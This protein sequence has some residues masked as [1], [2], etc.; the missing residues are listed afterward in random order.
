VVRVLVVS[1]RGSAPRE[2][3]ACMLVSRWGLHGTVGGGRLEYQAQQAAQ[4]LLADTGGGAQLQ[5]F[6]LGA[7]L[8]QCCGGVVELWIERY[9]R[10]ELPL[11]E[12]AA[13]AGADGAPAGLF[14]LLR[15]DRVERRVLRGRPAARL[16]EPVLQ[17]RAGLIA[18]RERLHRPAPPLWLF[19]AGHVGQALVRVLA[20]LPFA[21]SWIDA[22]AALFPPE[23]P[24]PVRVLTPAAPVEALREAPPLTRYLVMTHDHALDYALCR[25]ILLRGDGAWLG[26][27]GSRSKGA[28]FRARLARE[29]LPPEHIAQLCCPVGIGGIASKH[30]AA[31]AVAV[32]AQLL[33]GLPA[34]PTAH[35]PGRSSA[36]TE[37]GCTRDCRT[38]PT[39]R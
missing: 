22:R 4:A 1:V 6:V 39:P 26:L 35:A 33:Q 27:I 15:E 37:T 3:G 9:T 34:P 36:P 21:L 31:I 28:R 12:Q 18:L 20:D 14:S 7:G 16:H 32:A 5:R 10:A 24:E 8:G 38:C 29:G 19:G 23:V 17:R 11:L 30:P 2:P 13:Q 25:A